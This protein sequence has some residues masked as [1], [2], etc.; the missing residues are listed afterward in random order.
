MD[1]RIAVIE[2]SFGHRRHEI[3]RVLREAGHSDIVVMTD[4]EML[5]SDID[6]RSDAI[7]RKLTYAAECML[8][9]RTDFKH[10]V[11]IEREKTHPMSY[12]EF[13]S[14]NRGK[15]YKKGKQR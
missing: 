15:K 12:R 10:Y 8:A 9:P 14:T 2:G 5:A 4:M 1:K 13:R 7:E 6:I 11:S 3:E